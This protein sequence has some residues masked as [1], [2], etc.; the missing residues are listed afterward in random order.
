MLSN[1]NNFR[2]LNVTANCSNLTQIAPA[3]TNDTLH[4]TYHAWKRDTDA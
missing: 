3:N 1:S 4:H 2:Q